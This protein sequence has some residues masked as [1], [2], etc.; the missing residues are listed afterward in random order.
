MAKTRARTER[1]KA[2]P[3]TAEMV[4]TDETC[5]YCNRVAHVKASCRKKA[6]DDEQRRKGLAGA[7]QLQH[8][9]IHSWSAVCRL[10]GRETQQDRWLC[11][12]TRA[13]ETNELETDHSGNEVYRLN[14]L[15]SEHGYQ[16]RDGL[17]MPDTVIDT[18]TPLAQA[19]DHLV[20]SFLFAYLP[21]LL[22]T[23]SR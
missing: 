5:Y 13:L 2:K 12:I 21:T 15:V 17:V 7:C 9:E 6:R 1:I 20:T 10:R 23:A 16:E 18:L 4:H 19:Q 22:L 8:S 14:R 11:A 3:T